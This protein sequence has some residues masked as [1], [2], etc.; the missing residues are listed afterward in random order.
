MT[1]P[2][3]NDPQI[4]RRVFLGASA[5][6]AAGMAAAGVVGWTGAA[7]ARPAPSERVTVGVIGIRNQGKALAGA[8]A[9]FKDVNVAV[10][11]DVDESLLPHAARDIE[12][13]Q[14]PAPTMATD[15][16][17]LLDDPA[18]D[19]VVIATPDHWH[20]TMTILACQ[21]GKDV[22]VEKPVSHTLAEGPAMI[23]AAVRHQRI[24]QSGLQQRSGAHF[25]SAVEYIRSGK[26]GEV[27]LAKAWTVHQ[28]KTIGF[29]KNAEAPAGVNYDLWLGPA[30]ERPFNP[31]RFHYNWHWFWDYGTGELGNW[32]VHLLDVARWG[33]AVDLP[34]QVSSTGGK[35][36]FQDDQQ[37]PDT[38][39]VNYAY[40]GKTITWEHRL[41]S[42][43]GQEG[44]SAAVAFCGD[45]G[46]L[47]V[48]RGGWKIYGQKDAA[49]EGTSELLEPHLRNF[50]ECIR[51]RAVPACPLEIGHTSSALCHLGNIAY[52][53]GRSIDV[54]PRSGRVTNDSAAAEF[55]G[56]EYRAP[57]SLP[58]V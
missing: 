38:L 12:A 9:G 48:D 14:G 55:T 41:W 15:F 29:R 8:L 54:D 46:T 2:V 18:L 37:T 26:L 31:N 36:H 6:N 56:S 53:R 11:C 57:W 51:S 49:T 7:G 27:H 43:H 50:V 25:Q 20:A 10:L 16:R 21:A 19:A 39:F 33:L 5:A 52:R 17:R 32:G 45:R 1:K 42:S 3:H 30:A 47:I 23:A 34:M 40:P 58:L 22:Y 13:R 35:H 24:V 44:R 4:N 28:R